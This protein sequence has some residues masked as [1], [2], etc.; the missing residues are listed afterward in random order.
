MKTLQD[1]YKLINEGKGNKVFF[2]SQARRLFPELV[3][4]YTSYDD[5]VKILK[6]KRVLTETKKEVKKEENWKKEFNQFLVEAKKDKKSSLM[7]NS[8]DFEDNQKFNNL[9]GN[10][11]LTGFIAEMHDKKNREK[12]ADQL[13]DIVVKNL[14]KDPLHYVKDGQFATK[15]IGYVQYPKEEKEIKGKYK[16]SGMEIVKMDKSRNSLLSEALGIQKKRNIK[17]AILY[18]LN[19]IDTE[20]AEKIADHFSIDVDLF[21]EKYV[22]DLHAYQDAISMWLEGASEDKQEEMYDML[23]EAGWFN[24]DELNENQEEKDNL[25]K[26][27]NG[28]HYANTEEGWGSIVGYTMDPNPALGKNKYEL[29]IDLLSGGTIHLPLKKIKQLKKGKEDWMSESK[30]KESDDS[31]IWNPEQGDEVHVSVNK[32]FGGEFT[33]YVLFNLTKNA[34][35]KPEFDNEKDLM[36][37]IDKKELVLTNPEKLKL[38]EKKSLKE[39]LGFE[40]NNLSNEEKEEAIQNTIE[41]TDVDGLVVLASIILGEDISIY[42]VEDEGLELAERLTKILPELSSKELNKIYEMLQEEG[43]VAESKSCHCGCGGSCGLNE[44]ETPIGIQDQ[45]DEI[46]TL[47]KLAKNKDIE[48]AAEFFYHGKYQQ[49]L[50]KVLKKYKIFDEV[51]EYILNNFENDIDPAGGYGLESHI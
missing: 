23:D 19:I 35:V 12:T 9:N 44:E 33:Q 10:S 28:D 3:N 7:P 48:G 2:L 51:S 16:S 27:V 6:G 25:D 39:L 18:V 43:L 49:S 32:M 40:E 11:L 37:F 24:L 4:Q 29:T 17:E 22:D 20:T 45:A 13:M 50:A 14:K 47:A 26:L 41:S 5:T 1:Q 42:D 46:N 30:L 15:G 34:S 8:Y 31:I 21:S 38:D 36:S